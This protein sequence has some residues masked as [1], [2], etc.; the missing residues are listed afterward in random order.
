MAL[1][2]RGS[3]RITV[4]GIQFFWQIRWRKIDQQQEKLTLVL[5]A[6]QKPST[7]LFVYLEQEYYDVWLDL[8]KD[9]KEHHIVL[10]KE[11]ETWIRKA[12]ASGWQ[13][14]EAGKPFEI[15]E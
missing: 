9:C 15:H 14:L 7:T 11:V 3:R 4:E 8:K 2:K 6:Q 12:L 1:R 10:P 5:A 13:P